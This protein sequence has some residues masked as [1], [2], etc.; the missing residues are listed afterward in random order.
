METLVE[1]LLKFGELF[2]MA[3][4]SQASNEEGVETRWEDSLT[5]KDE[6]DGI[7]Q[8]TNQMGSENYSGM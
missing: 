1:N 7:V 6:G 4:P 3:I 2:K 5:Y 8:T